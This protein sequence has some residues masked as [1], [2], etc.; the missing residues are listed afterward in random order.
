MHPEAFE[1]IGMECPKGALL[2]GPP[3]VG[4]TLL[5]RSVAEAT[6]ATLLAIS[7]SDVFD[8][9]LGESEQNLRRVFQEATSVALKRPC[10]LFIDE[11]DS[12]CPRREVMTANW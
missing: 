12:L 9:Y 6:G 1:R 3:G 7:G 2:H 11:I 8:A 10:I 5:V 4:K